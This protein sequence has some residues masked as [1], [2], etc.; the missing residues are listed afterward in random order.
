M[1]NSRIYFFSLLMIALAA[2]GT[3]KNFDVNN[4]TDDVYWSKADDLKKPLTV[5][6]LEM[7]EKS[8]KG[9]SSENPNY[10]PTNQNQPAGYDNMRAQS[11]YDAW[12]KQR[13]LKTGTDINGNQTDSGNDQ[14][15][16]SEDQKNDERDTRRLGT[17]R[18]Y[19]YDD[20]Y[21][22]SLS[23][24]WGWTSFY[25]PVYRPGFYS[26]AP[27]WNIGF[28]YNSFSGWGG[29]YGLSMGYGYGMDPFFCNSWYSPWYGYGYNN[30][31]NPWGAYYG[32]GYGYHPYGYF[33]YGY[34]P[35]GYYPYG[36]GGYHNG[37]DYGYYGKNKKANV[38]GRPMLHPRNSTGSDIPAGGRPANYVPDVQ[39]SRPVNSAVNGTVNPDRNN[40]PIQSNPG[41]IDAGVKVNPSRPS[42]T[43]GNNTGAVK[44]GGELVNDGNNRPVY[45]AP[46]NRPSN[47]NNP[48]SVRTNRPG[49]DLIPGSNGAQIYVPA[50]NS[51]TYENNN[52]Q[53]SYNSQ[54][55]R[56]NR[57]NQPNS[58]P[59][60]NP[61]SRSYSAPSRSNAPAYNA[62][63]RSNNS[64]APSYSAPSSQPSSAPSRSYSN[65]A[66]SG[67]T[68]SRGSSGGGGGSTTPRSRPR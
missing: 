50:R 4:N 25:A 66:P 10:E 3:Q 36:Y 18:T 51:A 46:N 64:P 61:P 30:F 27:G 21:Y 14:N 44:P 52:A 12:D 67:N 63:S 53:P 58:N 35:Y 26:W 39:K 2:C 9:P 62:P 7:K 17:E 20:P 54:P 60:Y 5:Q 24:N 1:K 57:N 40:Q 29:G 59:S 15:Y 28:G 31:Y 8:N 43:A 68:P 38:A 23:S 34:Y 65:P 37:Y 32:Y 41:A 19:Y 56:N 49:G 33:P 48:N 22:N 11:A 45:I 13:N 16:T 6:D 42:N 47:S 55:D